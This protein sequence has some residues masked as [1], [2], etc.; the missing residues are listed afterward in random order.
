MPTD[1]LLIGFLAEEL[2]G[3]LAGGRVD[4]VTQPEKD[5]LLLFAR[6]GG[7]NARLLLSASPAYARA[8][9]TDQTYVNPPDA[10]MFCMLMRKHLVGGRILSLTQERGDRILK[11]VIENRDELGESAQREMYLELMG[12]HSNLTLVQSGRVI[13]AVRHVTREMSRVRQALPGV[14]FEMPPEQ[15]NLPLSASAE[16]IFTRLS[17]EE[18]RLDLALQRTLRGLSAA[19][20]GEIAFRLTG[21]QKPGV[22][23]I[24]ARAAADRLRAFLDSLPSLFQP[25]AQYDGEGAIIDVY[26][27]PYLSRD[28]ALQKPFS[29]LCA[30]LDAYFCGRDRRDRMTQRST[31]LRRLIKTHIERAGR[32][33]ALQEEELADSARMEEY[34][35]WG[36]LLTAQAHLVPRGAKSAALQNFYDENGGTVDIPLDIALTPAQNAQLYFKKYRKARA[37]RK[38]AA[39]QKEKTLA[40]IDLLENAMSDLDSCEDESDLTDVRTVL[41]G[42][43]LMR[44][45]PQRG[46]NKR[47]ESRPAA[48]LSPEG[49]SI[50]VGKNAVQNERLTASARGGD[51]WLHAKDMPGSHVLVRLDGQE[52]PDGTLACAL[53]LA[54]LFSKGR[55]AAVPVDYTLRKY[56]K[57]PSGAAPGFVIYTNQKTAVVTCTEADIGQIKRL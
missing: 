40:E 30:A 33:L 47:P 36:E 11:I 56:V 23:D 55:G 53:K 10:P 1:G 48:F 38:L 42:A 16:E 49:L 26:P 17:R 37:A 31:A 28:T 3:A 15:D 13:D 20:A 5:M 27:F 50:Y 44:R 25:T 22:S 7:R 14:A 52:A 35:V 43:G 41:E 18:G 46:R 54:A 39:E 8:H 45:A 2:N 24:D 29:S 12:R 6:A 57:K 9:L 34:R 21:L 32:K 51:L 19:T 4:R